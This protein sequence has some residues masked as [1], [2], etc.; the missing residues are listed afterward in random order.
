MNNPFDKQIKESLENFEMPY[1]ATAWSA[2]EQQLPAATT[3][4]MSFGWKA[5]ITIGIVAATVATALYLNKDVETVAIVTPV[6]KTEDVT[7]VVNKKIIKEEAVSAQTEAVISSDSDLKTETQNTNKN[8]EPTN[9]P[10]AASSEPNELSKAET[11]EASKPVVDNTSE[12]HN[13]R[14]TDNAPIEEQPFMAKFLPSSVSVCAGDDISFINESSDKNATMSWDFG[15]GSSSSETDP[16]HSFVLPG[17]YT[18]NLLVNKND[19]EASHTVSVVV[20]TAPMPMLSASKKLEEYNAIPLYR[21]TTALQPNETA[22]WSFSDG[23]RINGNVAEHLFRNDGTATAKLTVSNNLGCSTSIDRKYDTEEFKLLAPS[24]FT[25]N[26]DGINETFIPVAL[27]YMGV[28]FEMII[29]SSK[30]GEIVYQ[31]S[32]ASAPWNGT[33]NNTGEKLASGIYIWTVVLKENIVNNK[34]FKNKINL[35]Q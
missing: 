20:N 6:E 29:K 10:T 19:K 13:N 23:S 9:S 18:V 22:I 14:I 28:E 2:L 25:P 12:T 21:F 26:G 16:I 7:P 35:Q 24:G 1:D 32:N 27:Q 31:T 5:A 3:G 17:N 30:T 33:L 34:V 11:T 15:D 8:I 4:S